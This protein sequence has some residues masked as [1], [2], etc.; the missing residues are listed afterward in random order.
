MDNLVVIAFVLQIAVLIPVQYFL[1]IRTLKE[2]R[3][4]HEMLK[5]G[6]KAALFIVRRR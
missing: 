2:K 3:E 4:I 5:E 1:F 6:L